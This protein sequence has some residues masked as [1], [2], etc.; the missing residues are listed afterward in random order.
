[1]LVDFD[2]RGQNRKD[3]LWIIVMIFLFI[4]TLV[5]IAPIY[6]KGSTGEQVM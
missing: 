4:W 5:L 2:V 6:Y 3:Y 1:M